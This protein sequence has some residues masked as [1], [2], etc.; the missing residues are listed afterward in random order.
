MGFSRVIALAVATVA[1]V[2]A[3]D[4]ADLDSVIKNFTGM[5]CAN[6]TAAYVTACEDFFSPTGNL[7]G[8]VNQSPKRTPSVR[9]TH[10]KKV[11]R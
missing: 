7:S 8:C 4:C 10:I 5:N 2:A 1:S 11:P 3:D 9:P 6:F